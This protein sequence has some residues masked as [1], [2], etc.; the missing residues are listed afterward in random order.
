MKQE[1]IAML[2]AGGKGTRLNALTR[3]VA[4]PAVNFG[5]KYRIIDFPLSNCA[6]STIKTVGVLTQY[7][8]ASL[9]EYI[10]NGQKWGLDANG[11]ACVLLAPGQKGNECY[12]YQGTADA[13][14]RNLSFI[15]K[16]APEYVLILS[17]DHV[18]KMDYSKMLHY[19]KSKGADVTIAT[20]N[21]SLK[22]ASRFGIINANE[23]LS[24]YEFEEKPE[25]PKS[26]LASMGIYIF[27]Y[28]KL[29]SY[30]EKEN[31]HVE[32]SEHDFGKHILPAMLEDKCNM[33]A[34]PFEGYWKDVGTVE[35]LWQSNMDLIDDDK[36]DLLNPYSN[37]KIYTED[38]FSAPQYISAD[39]KVSNCLINQGCYIEGE[40]EHSVIFN[41]VKIGKNAKVIDSVILP[42]CTIKDGAIIRK[43]IINK[44]TII[45]E[46]EKVNL[47]EKEILLVTKEEI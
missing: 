42:G 33:Y 12:F 45:E 18:Y 36:L 43:C 15:E 1:I 37:W 47:D 21:V 4:K 30:L 13:I 22:E 40:V 27:T 29:K 26:T 44:K 31:N 7:E 5:G 2:L 16:Y 19:H 28:A 24:I 38:S 11:N 6:N 3:T 25:H 41:D 9:T 20:I 14:Y 23:D 39:A 34:Y 32:R 8:G 17:G 10:G 35:S 46:N